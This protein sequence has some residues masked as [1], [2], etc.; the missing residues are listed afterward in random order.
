LSTYYKSI[1]LRPHITSETGYSHND[2]SFLELWFWCNCC[3]GNFAWGPEL[4]NMI[5]TVK[6]QNLC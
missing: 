5:F 6:S 1:F 3:F 2:V 4:K